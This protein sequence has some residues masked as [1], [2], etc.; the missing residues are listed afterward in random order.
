MT[1]KTGAFLEIHE[2]VRAF[3]RIRGK[4]KSGKILEKM[5]TFGRYLRKSFVKILEKSVDFRQFDEETKN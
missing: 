5:G 2:K 3:V 4:V 1:E